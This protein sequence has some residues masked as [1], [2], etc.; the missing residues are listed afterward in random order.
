ML[1]AYNVALIKNRRA[2]VEG[3]KLTMKTSSSP[4]SPER[5][6]WC[7]GDASEIPKRKIIKLYFQYI[8]QNN[9]LRSAYNKKVIHNKYTY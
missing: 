9:K 1:K 2:S 4:T 7:K 5:L 3:M 6:Y 8:F